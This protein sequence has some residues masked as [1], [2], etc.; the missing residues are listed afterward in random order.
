[1]HAELAN[2]APVTILFTWCRNSCPTI[3]ANTVREQMALTRHSS[4]SAG[5]CRHSPMRRCASCPPCRPATWTSS[6]LASHSASVT[7]RAGPKS[8]A[9]VPHARHSVADLVNSLSG[10]PVQVVSASARLVEAIEHDPGQ[11]D[12]IATAGGLR[13]AVFL[14]KMSQAAGNQRIASAVSQLLLHLA[15]DNPG[16]QDEICSLEGIPCL[17][18]VVLS[19]EQASECS[20]C[21]RSR[22]RSPGHELL[23]MTKAVRSAAEALGL[24]AGRH[25]RAIARAGGVEG[26][27]SLLAAGNCRSVEA[28]VE[29]ALARIAGAAVDERFEGR[30]ISPPPSPPPSPSSGMST[31]GGPRDDLIWAEDPFLLE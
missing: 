15:R 6:L 26:L 3:E 22:S 31:S 13:S 29:D 24:L 1:M 23:E 30:D 18:D 12:G 9:T 7:K 11:Q 21:P 27:L 17:V 25:A 5:S 10:T 28:V 2:R 14:L 8:T 19:F 20:C 4:S 16:N